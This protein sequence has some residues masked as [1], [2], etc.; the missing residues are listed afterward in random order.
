MARKPSAKAQSPDADPPPPASKEATASVSASGDIIRL[1]TI[2]YRDRR[3]AMEQRKRSD[4][5]IG[6]YLRSALGWRKDLP[7]AERKA[8]GIKAAA[9]AKAPAGTKWE[10]MILA[11]AESRKPYE[12]IED[13]AK[14]EMEGIAKAL[15]VWKSFG[16]DV[17]GFGAASLA[18]I[19]A[20]AGS[21]DN[22]AT[23]PRLWKRMGLAVMGDVRQGGL[24]KGAGAEAWIAHGYNPSRRSAMWNIGDTM[25]KAQ[26]RREKDANGEDT[27]GR[28]SLGKYG[29]LY[30]VRKQYEIA[31]NPEIQPIVAHR[32][33]QRVMEKR[34][35]KDLWQAWRRGQSRSVERPSDLC[36]DAEA[37]AA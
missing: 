11:Q 25:L 31:R 21:L 5:A 7:E 27:G 19:I 10:A 12:A 37:I 3:F 32:R 23:I 20:E 8:I 18:A 15:P 24:A 26:V 6:A 30:L 35:L 17:R 33:A 29:N 22:Y 9:I 36:P 16:K 2:L 4:L 14:K 1:I 13:T 28:V 34:L